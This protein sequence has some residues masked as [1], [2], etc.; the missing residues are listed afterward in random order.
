MREEGER[1]IL[2][3]EGSVGERGSDLDL[4]PWK[5]LWIQIRIQ[6]NDADPLD[7]DLDPPNCF[8][9]SHSQIKCILKGFDL[10]TFFISL[11]LSLRSVKIQK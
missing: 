1:L 6:Q 8:P 11:C 5:I 2:K 3:E 4:D 10:N 7:L 9:G